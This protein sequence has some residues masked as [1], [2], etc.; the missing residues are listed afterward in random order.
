MP[1]LHGPRVGLVFAQAE[2]VTLHRERLV[3]HERAQQLLG[4]VG[5]AGRLAHKPAEL[6]GGERQRVA[7]ARALANNPACVLMDEPT[8]NL[9]GKSAGAVQDLMRELSQQLATA[10]VVVTHDLKFAHTM[11]E[12]FE[13]HEGRLEAVPRGAASAEALAG[14]THGKTP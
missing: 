9:D 2:H 8:G 4:Q 11:D 7:I 14:K 12:V 13:L 5:L 3:A 10:F 1:L 6:S